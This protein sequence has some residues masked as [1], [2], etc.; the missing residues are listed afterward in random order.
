M[1]ELNDLSL[2][3]F[4]PQVLGVVAKPEL[5][6]CTGVVNELDAEVGSLTR[7]AALFVF[8]VV[9]VVVVKVVALRHRWAS[10]SSTRFGP[11]PLWRWLTAPL[12]PPPV[13]RLGGLWYAS[14]GV[15]TP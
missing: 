7:A 12:P 6:G 5:N 3:H 8:V 15:P 2:P 9:V 10:I 1:F 13:S 14:M 4:S 11:T